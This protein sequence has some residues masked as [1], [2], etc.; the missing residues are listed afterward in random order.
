LSA[1]PS[2]Q[3]PLILVGLIA[4]GALSTDM[5]LPALPA[6]A[7]GFGENEAAA[8]L[9]LSVF[10]FGLALGQLFY[11]PMSDRFGR[12]P[13]VIAGA[14]LYLAAGFGCATA[15]SMDALI[16]WRFLHGVG[17]SV[18]PVVGRAI[19]GDLY[20][21]ERGAAVL[22]AMSAAM[23]LLPAVAPLI[24]GALL[25]FWP[26]PAIFLALQ[27]FAALLLA[28]FAFNVPETRPPPPTDGDGVL[29]K[30]GIIA[31]Y[32]RVAASRLFW[33]YALAGG[34]SFAGMFV[35]ISANAHL[36]ITVL[37]VREEFYGF[38]FLVLPLGYFGGAAASARIVARLG[39][40]RTMALGAALALIAAMSLT[41][42]AA[43]EAW[44][45][46]PILLS[47]VAVYA[48]G[49]GM[50]LANA[51]VAGVKIFPDDAGAASGLA[52]FFQVAAAGIAGM[53]ALWFYDQ[54]PQ[55]MG[56]T[57]LACAIIAAAAI[58]AAHFQTAPQRKI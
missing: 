4:L 56:W 52:G 32:R 1:R 29:V 18:G 13:A 19:V 10:M 53:L 47:P 5:Y 8:Q 51:Q 31:R 50:T 35:F 46:L 34:L 43:G 57:M 45:T 2:K 36:V 17:A 58:A 38:A 25:L 16:L 42:I 15:Q 23:A 14:L 22:S 48:A 21:R 30:R 12:R 54:T 9:T 39:I 55:S 49:C 26:W 24:G 28:A 33:T 11:G 6:I 20:G 27:A 37:G 41:A 40:E 3:T 44:K 7:R